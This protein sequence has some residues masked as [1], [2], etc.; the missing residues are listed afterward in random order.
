[1]RSGTPAPVLAAVPGGG[2]GRGAQRRLRV[3]EEIRR[4]L[5]DIFLRAPFRDPE[6]ATARITV[7]EVRLSPD[8]RQA[9]A[10]VARLGRPDIAELLPALAR[11]TPFL[12]REV[13]RGIR[14]RRAPTL[15]FATDATL[16]RV[17]RI[18]EVLRSPAVARDLAGH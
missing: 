5:A 17:S 3:A 4:L 1:M 6:L 12:Q 16:E 15:T 9:T 2:P 8:L 11:A 7:T 18:E 10:F 14:L 13:A